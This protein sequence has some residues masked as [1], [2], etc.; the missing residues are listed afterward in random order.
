MTKT[1]S[2]LNITFWIVFTWAVAFK[3]YGLND[4]GDVFGALSLFIAIT[5]FAISLKSE[6]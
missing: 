3:S 1:L 4:L 5:G 6:R 2:A